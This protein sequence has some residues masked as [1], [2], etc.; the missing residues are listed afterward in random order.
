MSS[1]KSVQPCLADRSAVA[2]EEFRVE[3]VVRRSSVTGAG[4]GKFCAV[5]CVVS[6]VSL[7]GGFQSE[8]E[9]YNTDM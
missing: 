1:G 2:R 9:A 3:R 8:V 4:C 6:V 7:C 5:L